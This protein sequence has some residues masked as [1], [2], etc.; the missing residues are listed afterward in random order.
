LQNAPGYYEKA[1]TEIPGFLNPINGI[2]HPVTRGRNVIAGLAELGHGLLNTP[3]GIANYLS[4]R[5]NLTPKKWADKIPYQ[6]DISRSLN[7]FTGE[8]MNPGDAFARGIARNATSIIPGSNVLNPLNLTA[9]S[10]A[11]DVLKTREKNIS[12]YGNKYENLW[13]EAEGKGFGDALYNINVDMNTIKKYSPNRSIKGVEDFDKNP[14]LQNAH[15]AK[16]DLLRIKRDLDK[17]TTLRTAERQQLGAVNNAIDSINDNMF[18]GPNG[19]IHEGMKKK[20]NTLQEGYRNEVV[21]YKNK[22][23]NEFI[24]NESSANELVN[25]LSKRAF[26][27]KRGKNHPAI[28]IRN[29]LPKAVTGLSAIG[30]LGW[31]TNKAFGKN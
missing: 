21:P 22:A 17:L 14:T 12:N 4:N 5:L 10:I 11:K 31:L 15:N 6:D 2:S 1:K 23:I 29:N 16:S 30:G 24:R 7:Q 25:S 20:Y 8:E 3:H 13:K 26:Y 28:K 18:R 27:A 9:K 19:K